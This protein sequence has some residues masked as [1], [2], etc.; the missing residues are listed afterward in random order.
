MTCPGATLACVVR[1]VTFYLAVDSYRFPAVS[2]AL[3]ATAPVN[4]LS[5]GSFA[6]WPV[7]CSPAVAAASGVSFSI[8]G[9]TRGRC[10]ANA[11]P[12]GERRRT[13]VTGVGSTA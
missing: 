2:S 5:S 11:D 12:P 8:Y 9:L 4:R 1:E 3:A 7:L 13:R 6:P 10:E